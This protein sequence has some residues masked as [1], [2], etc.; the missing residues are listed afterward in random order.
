MNNS[1]SIRLSPQR[2]TQL[3][4]TG[5]LRLGGRNLDKKSPLFLTPH[6][7][8]LHCQPQEERIFRLVIVIYRDD[9]GTISCQ[10]LIQLKVIAKFGL[11]SVWPKIGH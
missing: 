2:G 4:R 11:T 8:Y 6:T 5:Q 7:V 9:W 10:E 3:V 1:Y